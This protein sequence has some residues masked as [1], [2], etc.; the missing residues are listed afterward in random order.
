MNFR[1]KFD[2]IVFLVEENIEKDATNISPIIGKD[3]GIAKRSVNESFSFITSIAF[4][5]YVKGRKHSRIINEIKTLGNHLGKDAIGEIAY[6]YGYSDRSTFDRA[7]KRC[8]QVTPAEVIK[9]GSAFAEMEKISLDKLLDRD[10]ETAMIQATIDEKTASA[11]ID[12]LISKGS[13]IINLESEKDRVL[14]NEIMECQ[15]MY[16]L[17]T[18]QVLLAYELSEDKSVRGIESACEAISIEC[19]DLKPKQIDDNLKDCLYLLVNN[20]IYFDEAATIVSD[21]RKGSNVDIRRIEKEYLEL[22]TKYNYFNGSVLKN[23]PYD[24]YMKRKSAT[25]TILNNANEFVDIK[26]QPDGTIRA[27]MFYEAEWVLAQFFTQEE[28]SDPS[29][30]VEEQMDLMFAALGRCTFMSREEAMSII[31]SIKASG[32]NGWRDCNDLY[33]RIIFSPTAGTISYSEF[34]NLVEKLKAY[35]VTDQ[36]DI[37]TIVIK[38]MEIGWDGPF[39]DVVDDILFRKRLSEQ[40]NIIG[41]EELLELEN[42]RVSVDTVCKIFSKEIRKRGLLQWEIFETAMHNLTET[43]KERHKQIWC[44]NGEKLAL[45]LS[46]NSGRTYQDV[47]EELKKQFDSAGVDFDMSDKLY[48]D[49]NRMN[50]LL[51][52]NGPYET[53]DYNNYRRLE[54]LIPKDEKKRE[55]KLFFAAIAYQKKIYTTLAES[56]ERIR[57]VIDNTVELNENMNLPREEICYAF[58]YDKELKGKK[59]HEIEREYYARFI[60]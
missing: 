1:E 25:L 26:Q 4:S 16:G 55:D 52:E 14:L 8:Y 41:V 13:M 42:D 24:V 51:S 50:A 57:G 7:F 11:V 58:L 54:E 34:L 37:Q 49:I 21:I 48:F 56:I 45:M 15:A 60:V 46:V 27:D 30:D 18:E 31:R 33:L 47:K 44:T 43:A 2:R 35:G 29:K 3:L 53:L 39:D 17:S 22:V 23:L 9:K 36:D 38:T 10:M 28:I 40:Y 32:L 12:D 19:R 6:K 20:N 59:P 5:D